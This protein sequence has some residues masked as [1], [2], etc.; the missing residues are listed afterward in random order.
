M[1]YYFAFTVA[2]RWGFIIATALVVVVHF[3]L[4]CLR[5]IPYKWLNRTVNKQT[6]KNKKQT[7]QTKTKTKKQ[8]FG[9]QSNIDSSQRTYEKCEVYFLL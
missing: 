8:T 3:V 2:K 4:L 5:F 7:K 1:A 9:L 6:N